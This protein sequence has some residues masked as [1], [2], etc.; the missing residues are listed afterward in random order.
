MA[1]E[2]AL[3]IARAAVGI[4]LIVLGTVSA[5]MLEAVE[6]EPFPATIGEAMR[7]LALPGIGLG[8]VAIT[9]LWAI[10]ALMPA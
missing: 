10:C 4:A 5:K 6:R 7:K 9:G 1:D 2:T 8:S 3:Y